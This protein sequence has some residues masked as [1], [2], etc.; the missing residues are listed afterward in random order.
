MTRRD[1]LFLLAYCLL[2][3]GVG[4]YGGRPL[5]MHES[6]LAQSSRE[7]LASGDWLVPTSGGRPWL[8]R[9]PLPQWITAG[10]IALF[11]NA[12]SEAVVRLGPM[13]AGTWAVLVAAWLAQFIYGP[14][15][16]LFSGFI[17][18]TLVQ[19]HRYATL[20][21]QDIFL[22]AI[23]VSALAWFAKCEF[24]PP[25]DESKNPL[26]T[27]SWQT[28]LFFVLLSL[29]NLVKGLA[30]GTAMV[31]IPIGLWGLWNFRLRTL[32]RW[33]WLWGWLLYVG[34][35]AVWPLAVLKRFPDVVELWNY[36]LGGRLNGA[37]TNIN[38]P[39][40]YYFAHLL[41]VTLPW[42][43]FAL[44]GAWLAMKTARRDSP[45]RF[46]LCWAIGPILV[47]T[48]ASGKHHHYMI[49]FLA[50]WAILA[51]RSLAAFQSWIMEH[52]PN[53]SL[54]RRLYSPRS[55]AASF[56]VF[57]VLHVGV[58]AIIGWKIDKGRHDYEFFVDA[59]KS[60][61]PGSHLVVN[62]DLHSMDV[63][64]ILFYLPGAEAV[65]NLTYL[66]HTAAKHPEVFLITCQRDEAGLKKL[67]SIER[68]M[69]SVQSRREISADFR[70]GLYR[71]RFSPEIE[72]AKEAAPVSP[73]QAMYR[74]D[75]PYLGRPL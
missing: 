44:A 48:M 6:V 24:S 50:P 45:E 31:L 10:F 4:V 7:M 17:L 38:Q 32:W 28:L 63:F 16:G 2:L 39:W 74:K 11:G 67:G 29:T 1:S 35:S 75:G 5:T 55:L 23:V 14:R 66:R 36:D 12:E 56:A 54:L 40:W 64:R 20:C 22:T 19:F 15:L 37:Y 53:P 18:A 52:R 46:L 49:H 27:R 73:M 71:L 34:V 21:E 61:P 69:Q 43:P 65:H 59:R 68:L 62:A 30:F 51:A 72:I 3:F 57:A 13:L 25:P 26:G 33:T 70:L 60:L 9:P 41:W 58:Y 47:F 8:E 42:T